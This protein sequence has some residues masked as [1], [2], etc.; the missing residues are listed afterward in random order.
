MGII[1]SIMFYH[2][3]HAKTLNA[4][5]LGQFHIRNGHFV[6]DTLINETVGYTLSI[7]PQFLTKEFETFR[8]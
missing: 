5:P 1:H 2:A 3:K 6:L 7:P 4:R 8:Y